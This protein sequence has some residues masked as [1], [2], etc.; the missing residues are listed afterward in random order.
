M[1]Q[2]KFESFIEACVN[3]LVG[4]CITMFFLPIVNYI[5]GIEMSIAQMSY[6]TFLFTIISVLRGYIIRRWFDGNIGRF[7]IKKKV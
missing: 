2:S 6:S 5:I 4:L 7:I 1:K 3:T